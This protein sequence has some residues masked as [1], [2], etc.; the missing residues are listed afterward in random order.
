MIET[1][2]DEEHHE[3]KEKSEWDEWTKDDNRRRYRELQ[4]DN[5]GYY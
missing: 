5:R 4:E 3:E 2:Y 1:D